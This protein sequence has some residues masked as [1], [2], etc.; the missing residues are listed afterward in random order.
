MKEYLTDTYGTGEKIMKKMKKSFL[1]EPHKIKDYDG[2]VV[3]FFN[4]AIGLQW[5]YI[6]IEVK[7]NKINSSS[8]IGT[9]SDALLK[10]H[11]SRPLGLYNDETLYPLFCKLM[12]DHY[13]IKIEGIF[14]S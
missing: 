9:Y 6:S 12:M 3:Y 5:G 7:D 13:K 2:K 1:C 8:Q 14:N 11:F 10:Y 4:W